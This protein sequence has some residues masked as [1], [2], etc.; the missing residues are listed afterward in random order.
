MPEVRKRHES[1]RNA[2]GI[3][4]RALILACGNSLRGDDAVGLHVVRELR[5]GLC[6][7]E[8]VIQASTQWTPEQAEA[9]SEAEVVIFVDASAVLPTG[10]VQSKRISPKPEAPSSFSH[11]CSPEGLLSLAR[12]IYGVVP[13]AAFLITIG[14][15]SFEFSEELSEAVKL[16]IPEALAQIKAV[17]SGVSL[18]SEESRA[19]STSS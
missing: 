2:M 8:T 4:N 7:P 6:E 18:P 14:A 5:A 9:I 16:A 15:Q 17:L 3:V 13:S 10:A 11:S 19:Q 12:Q 1:G